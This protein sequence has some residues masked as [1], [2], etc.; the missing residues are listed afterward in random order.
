MYIEI[1]RA[2]AQALG[3]RITTLEK[4][5]DQ[6]EAGARCVAVTNALAGTSSAED[7]KIQ[8][9]KDF[10][11]VCQSTGFTQKQILSHDRKGELQD[12]R[13]QVCRML[14]RGGLSVREVSRIMRRS[15][16]SIQRMA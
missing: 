3:L 5:V 6:L 14:L 4:R 2:V 12:A 9:S 15:C 10:G 16:R 8:G 7:E 13:Y 11:A 1:D